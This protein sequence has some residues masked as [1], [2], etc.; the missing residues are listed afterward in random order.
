MRQRPFSIAG[1]LHA[2]ARRVV[3]PHRR[4]L[5]GSGII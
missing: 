3:A 4:L 2:V 1:F 5:W